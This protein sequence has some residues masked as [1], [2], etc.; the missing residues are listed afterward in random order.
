MINSF[1]QLIDNWVIDL[2]NKHFEIDYKCKNVFIGLNKLFVYFNR[3]DNIIIDML[4]NE[5]HYGHFALIFMDI[6]YDY[7]TLPI[8]EQTYSKTHV[9]LKVRAPMKYIRHFFEND[10]NINSIN[11]QSMTVNKFIGFDI[12]DWYSREWF[13]GDYFS[14]FYFDTCNVSNTFDGYNVLSNR[15]RGYSSY[16]NELTSVL[17]KQQNGN[18][19]DAHV[20]HRR[21]TTNRQLLLNV[22][23]LQQIQSEDKKYF[24]DGGGFYGV[25][26]LDQN[27]DHFYNYY[28]DQRYCYGLYCSSIDSIRTSYSRFGEWIT[29]GFED[30]QF[31]TRYDNKKRDRVKFSH[32]RKRY[33]KFDKFD[34]KRKRNTKDKRKG[35]K[36]FKHKDKVQ[37]KEKNAEKENQKE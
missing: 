17:E 18:G 11:C 23:V 9:Q 35:Q 2:K 21:C 34:K 3:I 16:L 32:E 31:T 15:W 12:N 5:Y 8:N 4:Q 33:Y 30:C 37:K 19:I 22:L 29:L 7:L 24:D 14:K 10:I 6:L 36:K 28:N 27:H 13:I 26:G 25:C 20:M 1:A